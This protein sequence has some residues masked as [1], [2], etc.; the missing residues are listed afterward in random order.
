LRLLADESVDIAVV[1]ALRQEGHDVVAIVEARPGTSDQDVAE[2][3]RTE[4]RIL[5]TEDRDFGRLAFAELKALGSVVYMRYPSALRLE[6]AR[7]VV[8]FVRDRDQ[9]LAATFVVLQPGRA[10]I[11]R[12]PER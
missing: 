4:G 3:A 2:I 1:Q 11:G 9:Q 12:L 7:E 5:L 6:F 8:E 10:R